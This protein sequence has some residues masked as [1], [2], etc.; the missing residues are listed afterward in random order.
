MHPRFGVEREYAVRVM[1][2]LGDAERGQLL[3]GVEVEGQR[4]AFKSIVN[5]GGE[6][7]N[8]VPRRD[9]RRPQREVR[10][11]SRP[12]ASRSAG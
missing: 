10:K 5:G 9:H 2:T 6:G 3:E 8:T 4:A 12:S 1:G 7:L 11:L